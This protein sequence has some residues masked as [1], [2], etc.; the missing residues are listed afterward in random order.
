MLKKNYCKA[1]IVFKIKIMSEIMTKNQD[2][3]NDTDQSTGDVPLV[4]D[5]S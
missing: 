2:S 4:T 3:L 5:F 1:F